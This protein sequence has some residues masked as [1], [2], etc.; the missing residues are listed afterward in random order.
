MGP[1]PGNRQ[2][3]SG[4]TH[5]GAN[6]SGNGQTAKEIIGQENIQQFTMDNPLRVLNGEPLKP[7]KTSGATTGRKRRRWWR[8]W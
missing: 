5:P 3:S 4:R 6:K 7:M 1:L 2:P 8:L